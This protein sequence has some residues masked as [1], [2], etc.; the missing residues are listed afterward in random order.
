MVGVTL[1]EP[2]SSVAMWGE[3]GQPVKTMQLGRSLDFC[4]TTLGPL[5]RFAV[6]W[7]TAAGT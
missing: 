5:G 4:P 2:S 6:E 3:V 1:I 7:A